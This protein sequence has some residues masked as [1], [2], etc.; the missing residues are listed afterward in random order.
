MGD[1]LE[2]NLLGSSAQFAHVIAQIRRIAKFD[3]TVLI[4]GETGTGKELAARAVHYLST[5]ATQP[6]IPVNCGALAESLVESELFGHERGAF[7]DAKQAAPGL[8]SQ[9]EGGTLFLDEVDTLSLKAQASLLRFL[10]DRTY[11]RVGGTATRQTDIRLI[12]ASNATLEDLVK[13]RHFRRDLL[14][15]LKVMPLIMPPLRERG[16]DV[17]ELAQAFLDRLNRDYLGQTPVKRFHQDLT[18]ALMHYSW[19]GNIRELEHFIQREYLMC[20]GDVMHANLQSDT[21]TAPTE[22]D[23]HNA[24]FKK[25]KAMVI[26]DFERNYVI[27]AMSRARGNISRAARIAGQDRS[28]FSKL[29][30]KYR[31]AP[32]AEQEQDS[33]DR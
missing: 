15:R 18:D 26:A 4:G 31:V 2:L 28:A 14:Y 21:G 30:H 22:P 9:A 10:Q 16:K 32:E 6:F 23:R 33:A 24:V 13:S 19:P 25:A 8:I 29:V 5:R 20:D 27:S 17:V 12:A 1:I 3:V 7:T 11:R